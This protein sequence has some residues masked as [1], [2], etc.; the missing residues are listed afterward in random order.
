MQRQFGLGWR[1][2]FNWVIWNTGFGKRSYDGCQEIMYAVMFAADSGTAEKGSSQNDHSTTNN[3][4]E[5]VDEA[6]WVKTDGTYIYSINN[7][8]VNQSAFSGCRQ[9]LNIF[10]AYPAASAALM[11]SL[12]LDEVHSAPV[13]FIALL[14]YLSQDFVA[15]SLLLQ[16]SSNTLA[17]LG[18]RTDPSTYRTFVETRVYDVNDRSVH[19]F[20]VVLRLPTNLFFFFWAGLG[21]ILDGYVR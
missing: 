8:Q 1:E 9:T 20:T 15:F 10:R 17:I 12:L 16:E 19:L 21:P 5:G 2:G 13:Q 6:D 4:V 11:S 7:Q 3:Q 14:T 18:E